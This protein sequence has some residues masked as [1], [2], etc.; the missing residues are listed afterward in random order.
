[1]AW[2]SL[3]YTLRV[4]VVDAGNN[5]V[6]KSYVMTTAVPADSLT[7]ALII[8]DA[9]EA[10]CALATKTYAITQEFY[11]DAFALPAEGIQAEARAVLIG[12]DGTL[13]NKQHRTEIPGPELDVFLAETGEGA[14]IVDIA[15]QDVLDYWNLF[16]TTGEAT[17]SDGD[18]VE[19]DG[20]IKG[21]RRTVSKKHG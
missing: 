7:D 15:H 3:G 11:N 5:E 2:Q 4:R 18:S 8:I 17:L 14:N 1:M 13:P 21:Y 6:S 16:D 12:T 19:A 10:V 20:I 9:L